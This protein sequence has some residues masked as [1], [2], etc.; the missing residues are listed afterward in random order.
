MC[1]SE[2]LCTKKRAADAVLQIARG[3][4]TERIKDVAP[5]IPLESIV[6]MN[7]LLEQFMVTGVPSEALSRQLDYI[8]GKAAGQ[9]TATEK[10]LLDTYNAKNEEIRLRTQRTLRDFTQFGNSRPNPEPITLAIIG[11]GLAGELIQ[12]GLDYAASATISL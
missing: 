3:Y 2:F 4:V 10:A 8:R 6:G 7:S 1:G 5:N 9:L 12:G 11:I